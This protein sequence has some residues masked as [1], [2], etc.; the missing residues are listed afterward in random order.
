MDKTILKKIKDNLIN[1]INDID[2]DDKIDIHI[3]C[4]NHLGGEVFHSIDE[5]FNKDNDSLSFDFEDN[6]DFKNL[7]LNFESIDDESID[8]ESID[9]ESI[10]DESIDDESID[11]DSIDEFLDQ[12]K[13]KK[14]LHICIFDKE[15]EVSTPIINVES[16]NNVSF[17]LYPQTFTFN[18]ETDLEKWDNRIKN[19]LNDISLFLNPDESMKIPE[20][21]LTN[22]FELFKKKMSRRGDESTLDYTNPILFN[23]ISL[24]SDTSLYSSKEKN[25]NF[26]NLI[27]IFFNNPEFAKLFILYIIVSSNREYRN[28]YKKVCTTKSTKLDFLPS[29]ETQFNTNTFQSLTILLD[30]TKSTKLDFLPSTETQFNT[31]T[32]RPLT[33]DLDTSQE[34]YS[35]KFNKNGEEITDVTVIKSELKNTIEECNSNK[36]RFMIIYI[37]IS[38]RH[39]N[40]LIIDLKNLVAVRIEPHGFNV[41]SFYNQEKADGFLRTSIFDEF[42]IDGKQIFYVN[43]RIN[44]GENYANALGGHRI[45]IQTDQGIC[46]VV[47]FMMIIMTILY[48]KFTPMALN[49]IL[50]KNQETT[51]NNFEMMFFRFY[52]FMKI[53]KLKISIYLD[54]NEK[55]SNQKELLE[56][57]LLNIL[58]SDKYNSMLWHNIN[59]GSIKETQ[60][61]KSFLSYFKKTPI[62]FGGYTANTLLKFIFYMCMTNLIYN[63]NNKNNVVIS[64]GNFNENDE[65]SFTI[66][67]DGIDKI[68]TFSSNNSMT[69]GLPEGQEFKNANILCNIESIGKQRKGKCEQKDYKKISEIQLKSTDRVI[70]ALKT[71]IKSRKTIAMDGG[72]YKKSKRFKK[73]KLRKKNLSKK[74]N[75]KRR[76]KSKKLYK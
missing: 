76:N 6:D 52:E 7:L 65:G 30:T 55:L 75:S 70:E 26:Y 69:V 68:F 53:I 63:G 24:N 32:L 23:D 48:P 10:D 9:D 57:S 60:K 11:D 38:K 14:Y 22:D 51:Y 54:Y 49:K 42:V 29:T 50:S 31:N 71:N 20:T 62:K 28:L 72:R 43:G 45:S 64:G 74:L 41:E 40:F 2:T 39:A 66:K 3:Y 67:I 18:D 17:I 61:K 59:S 16:K 25:A 34:E 27:Q 37:I 36:E 35:V 58:D 12:I 1:K 4:N 19:I 15:Q 73:L 46:W 44:V 33:I 5:V 47:S 13:D 56:A 8:D 21:T